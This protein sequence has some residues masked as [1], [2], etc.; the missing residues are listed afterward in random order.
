MQLVSADVTDPCGVAHEVRLA[1]SWRR[2]DETRENL[3]FVWS[4]ELRGEPDPAGL[5]QHPGVWSWTR[6]VCVGVGRQV[7]AMATNRDR[8]RSGAG[9]G[10][11][12][13]G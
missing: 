13:D 10:V 12:G 5:P 6:P 11:M 1:C 8:T 3:D 9:A 4:V 2:K 7:P